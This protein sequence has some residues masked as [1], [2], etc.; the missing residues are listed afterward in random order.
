MYIALV[1]AVAFVLI[2]LWLL[3]FF[4]RSLAN[5][6]NHRVAE[7][8]SAV[9]WYGGKYQKLKDS[10]IHH[11]IVSFSNFVFRRTVSSLCTIL[12][13]AITVVGTMA[14][15]SFFTTWEGCTANK[16]FIGINAALC[17]L[18]SVISAL[19]CCGPS[20]Y[21]D[22]RVWV[23]SFLHWL[24]A[25][26]LWAITEETHSALLQASI[27][28]VYITYLTWTA[29]SSVPREPTPSPE[30]VQQ[31]KGLMVL[32]WW[33]S[34]LLTVC[35]YLL[36][37]VIPISSGHGRKRRNIGPD[38][39]LW[40]SRCSFRLQRVYIALR[41]CGHHVFL[42][43]LFQVRTT[44]SSFDYIRHDKPRPSISVDKFCLLTW[45][46][47]FSFFFLRLSLVRAE[48]RTA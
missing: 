10:A 32:W 37:L 44:P 2:Q 36:Q 3:V 33:M 17:L 22:I 20:T 21:E 43:G 26:F 12:C 31:P 8:G 45:A 39:L 29:L 1:G 41:G 24:I 27:I 13:F 15:F 35:L 34:L 38:V 6:I 40:T 7:G 4:A 16:I 25:N 47:F 28:S 48:Q 42:R 11:L 5:K 14:L 19:I 9:C 46:S 18:L 23:V 30:S